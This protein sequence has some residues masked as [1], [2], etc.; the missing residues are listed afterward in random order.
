MSKRA[1]QRL[2]SIFG[3]LSDPIR[4]N[5]LTKLTQ[6]ECSITTLSE[7]FDISS[8]AIT[9]HLR[10]LESSG[11]ITRRKEGRVNYCC[12]AAGPLQEADD[13]I[14][15]QRM[16]WEQQL[17]AL[18][19]YLDKEKGD[20]VWTEPRPKLGGRSASRDASKLHVKKSSRRGRNRKS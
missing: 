16:F 20:D 12:L 15:Q 9:K 13:W 10:V 18:T 4:R 1:N 2:D 8:P 5:I 11:L 19:K 14:R 6:G 17:D 7:P 3:A